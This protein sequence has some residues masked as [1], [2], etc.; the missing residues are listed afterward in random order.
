MDRRLAIL[1]N[2]CDLLVARPFTHHLNMCHVML[3]RSLAYQKYRICWIQM[4]WSPFSSNYKG[5]H[6]ANRS[7][8]Q[9]VCKFYTDINQYKKTLIE[10]N[11]LNIRIFLI[12]EEM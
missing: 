3:M 8:K 4:D 7:A 11:F 1:L 10:Y 12:S 6:P 5:L 2:Y 9:G